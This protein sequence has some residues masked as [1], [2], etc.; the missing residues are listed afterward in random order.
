MENKSVPAHPLG[1]ASVARTR[2]V[3]P[4]LAWRLDCDAARARTRSFRCARCPSTRPRSD[5]RET[6]PRP[7]RRCGRRSRHRPGARKDA[8]PGDEFRRDLPGRDSDIGPDHPAAGTFA[9]GDPVASLVS[10]ILTPLALEEIGP[11]VPGSERLAARGTAILFARTL[12]SP[13]CPGPGSGRAR[14]LRRRRRARGGPARREGRTDRPRHR[15]RQGGSPVSRRRARGRRRQR[16]GSRGRAR[17][18]RRPTAPARLGFADEVFSVDARD[19]VAMLGGDRGGDIGRA[20]GPRR[21]RG[22]RLGHRGRER[23]LRPGR[24]DRRLLRDGDVLLGRRSGRRRASRSPRAFRS[25]TASCPATTVSPSTS[26]AAIPRSPGRSRSSRED[27]ARDRRGQ[28]LASL[29]RESGARRIAFLGLAKNAGKTTA[30]TAVLA[31]LHR[32][33]V[34]AAAT[35]AGRDG[36]EFDAITGE[37]KPRFRVFPGQLVASARSTFE[38]ADVSLASMRFFRSR[39]GS[40]RWSFAALRARASSRS[41]DPPRPRSSR[42]PQRSSKRRARPSF[43]WTA[44]SAAGPSRPGGSATASCCRS[45]CPPADSLPQSSPRRAP[46]PS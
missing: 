31:E 23:S 24:R 34:R 36:E 33:G 3:L 42:G 26:S 27:Q 45:A 9:P 35:S 8:Q 38:A 18:R 39:R 22:Q 11:V 30:L 2:R 20:R 12:P 41:S 15:H 1:L 4:Q 37:P 40:G 43:F 5:L 46:P 28:A 44:P 25:A 13:G 7:A 19:P 10:L 14:R 17:P 6:E 29:L 32:S 16:A 21:Q